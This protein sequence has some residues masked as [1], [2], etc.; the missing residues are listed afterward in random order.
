ANPVSKLAVYYCAQN[1]F[2][3]ACAVSLD[4]GRTFGPG[5]YAYN[6]PAN[7]VNDPSRTIVAEGGAC[8]ALHGHLKVGPDGTAY[9]PVKG[10]GGTPTLANLTNNEYGGGFP[11]M[12]VS[13]DNGATWNVRIN[14]NGENPDQSD[15]S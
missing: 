11:A 6:T 9:L 5:R 1:G 3:G 8:S 15:N 7:A 13:T 12:S 2:N 4:G 14:P 10:C